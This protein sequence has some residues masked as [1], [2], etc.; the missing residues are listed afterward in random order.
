LPRQ[1]RCF[2]DPLRI[3]PQAP[4]TGGARMASLDNRNLAGLEWGR[5]EVTSNQKLNSYLENS[6][7]L[8][9]VAHFAVCGCGTG[10]SNGYLLVSTG[11]GGSNRTSI[12]TSFSRMRRRMEDMCAAHLQPKLLCPQRAL[13]EPWEPSTPP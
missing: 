12:W 13:K 8:R 7:T 3:C 11:Q 9:R 4:P 2:L 1:R 5:A 10:R 6:T